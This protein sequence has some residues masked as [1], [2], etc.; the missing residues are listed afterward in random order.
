VAASNEASNHL[1]T[2]SE[3]GSRGDLGVADVLMPN[4]PTL[5]IG[6]V[7]LSSV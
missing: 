1:R 5:P 2:G 7:R 4:L 3:K 6:P